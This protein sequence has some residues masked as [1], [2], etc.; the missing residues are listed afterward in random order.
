[1]TYADAAAYVAYSDLDPREKLLLIRKLAEW[2]PDD[3][4]VL[5]YG[6]MVGMEALA[7]VLD[8]DED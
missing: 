2:A 8:E 5:G 4:D 6:E 1:M 7:R 3:G